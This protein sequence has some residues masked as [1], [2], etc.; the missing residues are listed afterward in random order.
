MILL[1]F[2]GREVDLLDPTMTGCHTKSH[3]GGPGKCQSPLLSLSEISHPKIENHVMFLVNESQLWGTDI[4]IER[5]ITGPLIEPDNNDILNIDHFALF[6][7]LFHYLEGSKITE[8]V[9]NITGIGDC[10]NKGRFDHQVGIQAE[11]CFR[12]Y[13]VIMLKLK[14]SF[15]KITLDLILLVCIYPVIENTGLCRSSYYLAVTVI[16]DFRTFSKRSEEHTSELQSRPH[17]V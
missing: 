9:E 7:L 12:F 6:V 11:Y 4:V 10:G 16:Q 15:S 1:S 8:P 5:I 13:Q 2:T 3:T 17:L 14:D